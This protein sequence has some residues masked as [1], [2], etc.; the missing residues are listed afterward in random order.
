MMLSWSSDNPFVPPLVFHI[1][2]RS[3]RAYY[4]VCQ[5][6]YDNLDQ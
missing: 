5:S 6:D 3:V 1:E 4:E 2:T